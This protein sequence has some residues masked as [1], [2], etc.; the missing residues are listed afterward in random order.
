[1]TDSPAAST[2]YEILGVTAAVSD[3]ELKRAY[4]RL[5]RK[6]HPDAGGSATEFHAVQ[7]AWE[8][9]G[10]PALRAAYDRSR[11]TAAEPVPESTFATGRSGTRRGQAGPSGPRARMHGHPGGWS[12]Q[13]YLEL[14]REW[15]GRG[16]ALA[17]PYD[18]EL[19]RSAPREIR[20][21][22]AKAGAE[23]MTAQLISGLGIGYTAWHDVET[24]VGTEKLDHIVLGPAGLFGILSE[25]WGCTVEVRKGELIGSLFAPGDEPIDALQA[26]ARSVTKSLR[27]RFTALV[28]VVPDGALSEPAILPPRGR[29]PSVVVLT[30]S[31]LVGLLRDGMPGLQRGS[32]E[33]VFE[34]RSQLQNGIRFV[35]D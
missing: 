35:A 34:L 3:D 13:R 9:I 17:D 15:S 33:K 31:R 20:H 16:R 11:F 30:R 4:R 19:V 32:F 23:E 25:D 5:L 28:V 8:R 14:M 18:P 22:L 24:G 21:L 27:V 12:R 10:T 1:M 6:T 29:R 26:S 2:P 7:L